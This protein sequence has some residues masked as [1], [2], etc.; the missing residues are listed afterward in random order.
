MAAGTGHENF[1][2][3]RVVGGFSGRDAT[4]NSPGS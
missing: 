1:L 2:D 3:A 4:I